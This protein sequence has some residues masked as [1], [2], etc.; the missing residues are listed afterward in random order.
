MDFPKRKKG[1]SLFIFQVSR[2]I[3]HHDL[4]YFTLLI[5]K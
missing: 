3:M 5:C 2:I 1:A 4:I